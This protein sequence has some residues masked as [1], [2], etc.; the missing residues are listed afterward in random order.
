MPRADAVASTRSTP[1]AL[2]AV[3]ATLF[4]LRIGAGIVQHRFPPEVPNFVSWHSP[5]DFHQ[6]ETKSGKP[7]LFYFTARWCGPCEDLQRE[8]FAHRSTGSAINEAFYPVLVEDRRVEDGFNS[9][10]TSALQQRFSIESFPTMVAVAVDGQ[11]P[12]KMRGY[13][14]ESEALEWLRQAEQALRRRPEIPVD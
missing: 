9:E 7:T 10:Q 2:L 14:G 6:R 4:L 12:M 1:R 8:I 13:S 3:A 5:E 11:R